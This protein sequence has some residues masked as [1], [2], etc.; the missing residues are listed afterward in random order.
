MSEVSCNRCQFKVSVTAPPPRVGTNPSWEMGPIDV[1][2]Q[3]G[4]IS[5]SLATCPHLNQTIMAVYKA[6]KLL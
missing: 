3:T 4:C 1:N 6:G 2:T 5:P